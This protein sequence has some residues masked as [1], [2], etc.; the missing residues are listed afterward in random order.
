[1]WVMNNYRVSAVFSAVA[2]TLAGC[3]SV[4]PQ[5]VATSEIVAQAKADRETAQVDVEP[6]KGPVGLDDAI[7][8]ALKYNL[9]RRT[10]MMEEALALNQLDVGRYD[11]LPK[12]VAA[13]G[14]SARSEYATTRSIDS[15]TGAPS[16]AN[17]SI[18]S[19]KNH[20]VV[21]LGLTW[22][23]LDFGVSYYNSKQNAD[24]VL[25]A[26]ERR[27]K[28]LHLLIQDVRTAFWRTASAQKLRTDVRAAIVL[29]EE[30]LADARKS[31]AERVRSP[32]DSLRYQ[33]QVLENVRLL[34]AIDQDLATARVELAHLINAP[35]A[36]DLQVVEPAEVVT[37]GLLDMPVE[38][39]EESAIERNADLREQMYGARISRDEAQKIMLRLF[40]SLS[41]NFSLKNDNDQFLVHNRWN[42]AGLQLSYN[43]LNIFSAPALKRLGEAGIALADQRRV[44]TQMAVLAQVHVARLQY[45]SAFQQ[46]ARADAIYNVDDRINRIIR[47]G[48]QAQTQSK[49]DRVSS[50]TTTILS[51]LRR[52]QALAQLHAASSKLQASMGVEPEVPSV[53]ESSLQEL[54]DVAGQ[55]LRQT[56][57]ETSTPS[58]TV[59]PAA[60]PAVT[61]A[62][63]AAPA[64]PAA[65]APRAPSA[66]TALVGSGVAGPEVLRSLEQWAAAWSAENI[67]AYL[68]TY[69]PDFVPSQGLSMEAWARQR[70]ERLSRSG[71]IDITVR[72]PEL[73]KAD[74]QHATVRFVQAYQSP[75]YRDVTLK[76]LTWSRHNGRWLIREERVLKKVE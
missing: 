23:L 59:A 2:V 33:R 20:A 67:E 50:N 55:F 15:V 12:V 61:P 66:P 39:M 11:M 53:R 58:A 76:Q 49:L 42:E 6:I 71:D 24:R 30:A 46:F 14:Y 7:A 52:Y 63:P 16:L 65:Q 75:V 18:S 70:R 19:D 54:K 60:A 25:V 51:L 73:V 41:F 3:A 47:A 26:A 8:R 45:I 21:D 1:M 68:A 34:E 28:A 10:R 4:A 31:E 74:E 64:K 56:Q 32:L 69:A 22:N 72:E 29:A 57:G 13:A 5:P 40:P 9:E 27:R 17:P 43:L 35:L 38:K 44:A 48:E 37:R 36:V 62:A